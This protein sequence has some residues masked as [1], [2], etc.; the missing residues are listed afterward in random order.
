VLELD[1]AT[2]QDRLLGLR[3]LRP[4]IVVVTGE[5]EATGGSAGWGSPGWDAGAGRGL[6]RPADQ[7][8]ALSRAFLPLVA[9]VVIPLRHAT[10]LAGDST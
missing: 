6:R 8:D 9:F 7:A 5:P 2:A 3:Q 4:R 10:R 1:P